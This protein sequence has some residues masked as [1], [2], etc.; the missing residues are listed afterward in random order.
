MFDE[1]S[2]NFMLLLEDIDFKISQMTEFNGG[3]LKDCDLKMFYKLKAVKRQ[4]ESTMYEAALVQESM[5]EPSPL[6]NPPTGQL[7]KFIEALPAIF[8]MRFRRLMPVQIYEAHHSYL[9]IF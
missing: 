2:P 5:I 9:V 3:K 1:A 4:Q 6:F 7:S 8:T